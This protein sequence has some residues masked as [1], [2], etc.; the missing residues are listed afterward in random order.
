[1][2]S[3]VEKPTLATAYSPTTS[4]LRHTTRW[5]VMMS[6]PLS[7]SINVLAPDGYWRV[8]AVAPSRV[9]LSATSPNYCTRIC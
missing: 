3:I 2:S 1:M 9:V 7:L 6:W 8:D 4:S 5:P